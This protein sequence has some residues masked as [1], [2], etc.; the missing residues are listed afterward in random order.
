MRRNHV[1]QAHSQTG[2]WVRLG[3]YVLVKLGTLLW[4][5]WGQ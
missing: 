5:L 2:A 1:R 3:L 4:E